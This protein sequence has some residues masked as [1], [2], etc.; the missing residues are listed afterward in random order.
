MNVRGRPLHFGIQL[1]AQGTGWADYAR[2]VKEVE[3]LGFG[4]VWTFDHLL[5]FSG[6]DDRPCF[7]TLTTLS[8]LALLTTTARIGVLVNGVLYRDPAT[9]AK[10]AAQVDQMSGG[11]LDFSLGAAW[12][13]R[14]FKAYGLAFPPLAERY[15]RLD[16]A[17]RVV[18]LLW[19]EHRT[20]F[21]GR[22]YHLDEAPCEPKPLQSPHP[23]ITIGGTG[24]GS[25]RAA[26]AHA[27]RLNLVGPPQKCADRVASLE[28]LCTE[29]G[30]DVTEIELS[31]HPGL[32]LA[33]T[34]AEAEALGGRIAASHS[35]E[36][37]ANRAGWLIGDPVTV[38]SQLQRYFDIGIN[39]FVMALGHPFDLAPLRLFRDE[40]L[41]ALAP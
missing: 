38:V 25:L 28:R 11:R 37:E 33:P 5:P 32:A 40:V 2:A 7:E 21:E 12:A 19:S 39:H 1:Q 22:Y 6:A 23:P 18:K 3:Q 41:P 31:V 17:L 36:L 20:T 14:E 4:S 34:S 8:A 26:A 35:Q 27:D 9:L 29:I 15:G 10:A 24:L 30:R 13:E 16:E